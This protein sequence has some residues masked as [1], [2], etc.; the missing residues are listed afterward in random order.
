MKEVLLWVLFP[1]A[2]M[3][4]WMIG[5]QINKGVRRFG[6]PGTSM[7]GA[8]FWRLTDGEKKSFKETSK[9][10]VLLLLIPVLVMGYGINSKLMKIFKK[11]LTVRIAYAIM[12]S[13]PLGIYAIITPN[14][15]WK[16]P[17]ITTSLIVAFQVRAGSLSKI[18]V[19]DVLIEDMVRGLV[20]GY[21]LIWLIIGS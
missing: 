7:I 3:V 20:L 9:L 10:L 21:S 15:F 13:I 18:G 11:D 6:I 16:Y 8:V 14:P 17:I 12:V 2:I 5:G 1:P 4:L 19:Y